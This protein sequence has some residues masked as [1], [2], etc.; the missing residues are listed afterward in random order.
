MQVLLNLWIL[1]PYQKPLLDWRT[2]YLTVQCTRTGIKF[3]IVIVHIMTI[4]IYSVLV[5]EFTTKAAQF[6]GIL[7]LTQTKA[8]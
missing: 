5:K 8:K 4:E 7:L 2:V 1:R 6:M 3:Q